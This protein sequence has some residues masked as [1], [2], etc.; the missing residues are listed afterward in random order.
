MKPSGQAVDVRA[1]LRRDRGFR[2]HGAVA[3]AGLGLEVLVDL[4]DV[5][6]DTLP[7]RPVRVQH[8]AELLGRKEEVMGA[9]HSPHKAARTQARAPLSE[10]PPWETQVQAAPRPWE[11]W[12]GEIEVFSSNSEDTF[13]FKNMGVTSTCS[14]ANSLAALKSVKRGSDLIP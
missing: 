8:L 5:L 9:T 1:G 12:S 6:H 2:D 10:P 7:V 14:P 13:P 11:M 4:G 3:A